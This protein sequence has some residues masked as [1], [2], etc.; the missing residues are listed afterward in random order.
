MKQIKIFVLIFIALTYANIAN[1]QEGYLCVS[2]A[3]GGVSFDKNSQK[4]RGTVFRNDNKKILI[5]KKNDKWI[6]KEFD[7]SFETEC[8]PPNE[9]GY[10]F[11]NKIFGEL[12]FNTKNKRYISTYLSGYID[13]KDNNDNTPAIEIGICSKL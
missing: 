5:S 11:C 6:V 2:E 8:E 7:N 9:Y 10:M 13:G 3:A 4:W 1:A 12:K